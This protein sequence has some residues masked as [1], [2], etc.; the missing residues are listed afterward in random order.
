MRAQRKLSS[1]PK[2]SER[3]LALAGA[4]VITALEPVNS[5]RDAFCIYFDTVPWSTVSGRVVKDLALSE[6]QRYPANLL[7]E[8]ILEAEQRLGMELALR[9][10]SY[11]SRSRQEIEDKLSR[12]KLSRDAIEWVIRKLQASDYLNDDAFVR[13]WINDRFELKGYGRRRIRNELLSKGIGVSEINE[14]LD[15][16]YPQSAERDVALKLI[17]PRL[18]RYAGLEESVMRRRLTQFLLRRGFSASTT[19]AVLRETT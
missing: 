14:A 5:R 7:R 11:R 6:G 9:L 13:T 1:Q 19:Q 18:P 8:R 10:F 15:A 12:K 2:P 3:Q 17:E 16:L 4:S